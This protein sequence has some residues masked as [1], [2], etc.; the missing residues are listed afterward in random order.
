M[1][2][3]PK[4]VTGGAFGRFLNENRP[5]LM[6]ECKGKPVTAVVKLASERFKALSPSESA[7]YQKMYMDAQSKYNA[8][9]AAFKAAGGEVSATK[10][11][12]K[13]D[14]DER[15]G[16]RRKMKKEKDLNAP[17]KPAGGAYGCYMDKHRSALIEE[18][19]GQPITAISKLGGS[20]FKAL[21]EA[22][23]KPYEE[24]YLAKKKAYE[25]AMK[26]YVPPAKTEPVAKE[27]K[28]K[29]TAKST[30]KEVKEKKAEK[31]VERKAGSLRGRGRGR[32]AKAAGAGRGAKGK[33]E[34]AADI[35][36]NVLAKAEKSKLADV[37]KKLGQRD[38]I[39]AS[40]ASWMDMLKALEENDGL[41]HAA[42][43]AI[44]DQRVA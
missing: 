19:K 23:R 10:R 37:L 43:R 29:S 13:G 30:A 44:L 41:L 11:K 5:K 4:K 14:E 40:G 34:A 1:A 26:K 38:D 31:V 20:R 17:K 25:E 7:R 2:E 8:D 35:P 18:C 42:K 32:G 6:E 27:T 15:P 28:E 22:E 24:A 12:S 16:K 33:K 36:A 9:L 39:K 3:Q 21:S